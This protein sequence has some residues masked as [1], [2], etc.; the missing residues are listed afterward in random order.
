MSSQIAGLWNSLTRAT[1]V[2]ELPD[3]RFTKCPQIYNNAEDNMNLG[4]GNISRPMTGKH[5]NQPKKKHYRHITPASAGGFILK[6]LVSDQSHQA[7]K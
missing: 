6:A 1:V 5:M 4:L 7:M 3:E 2:W